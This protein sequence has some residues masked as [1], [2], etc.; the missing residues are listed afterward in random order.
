[1]YR[2]FSIDHRMYCYTRIRYTRTIYNIF[3]YRIHYLETNS[4]NKPV[5]INKFRKL[6]Q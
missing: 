6:I 2:R 4:E 5:I 1:M 3:V